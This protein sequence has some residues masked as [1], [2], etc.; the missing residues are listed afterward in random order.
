MI[1]SRHQKLST[2]EIVHIA[3]QSTGS[4]YS[5]EQVEAAL[6]AEVHGAGAMLIREGNTL[7][8]LHRAP[9]DPSIGVFRALNA[10]TAQNYLQNSMRFILAMKAARFRVLVSEFEDPSILNIF[11]YIS[12]NPPFPGMGYEARRLSDGTIRATINMGD[13]QRGG[14]EAAK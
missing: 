10:D 1:D 8:V 2:Q 5:P 7:F 11:N 3:A 4:S 6:M 12:R 13:E 14:L 9:K